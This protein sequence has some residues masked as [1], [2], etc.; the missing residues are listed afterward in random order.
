MLK[1][2]EKD[3]LKSKMIK[4]E[5]KKLV[6]KAVKEGLGIELKE[7]EIEKPKEE[8]FGDYSTNIALVIGEKLKKNP[9]EIANILSSKFPAS[10]QARCGVGKVQSSKF[11]EKIEMAG[12]GFINFFLAKN[13]LIKELTRVLKE[14]EKYGQSE[15]GKGKT[16]VIDYSSPNIAK[17][18]GMG[19]LR[20]TIIG[21]AIYNIYKFLGYKVIGDNHLG[22]WGTQFGKLI[23]AIKRRGGK[24]IKKF[25]IENLEKFY[26]RFH[27]EAE[28]NL[29]LENEARTWFKKLEEGD[30]EAKK[31]WKVCV[32][33]SLKEFKRIYRLLG[34]KFDYILGESFYQKMSSEIIEEAK[35]KK[36]AIESQGAIIIQY[37]NQEFP[38]AMLLKSDKATTYLTRD[39]ATIKYRL[40]KWKPALI[41]YEVGADQELYFKQLFRAAE[42][43]GWTKREKFFHL[44]HG[45]V[46]TKSGK[47]STRKGQTVHL[48]EVLE[49]AILRA[50]EIIEKSETSRGLSEKE[51]EKVAKAVGIGAI[52]YNDLSQHPSGDIIFD[53][54]KILNLKGNSVPYLQYTFARCQSVLK[55][56]NFKPDTSKILLKSNFNKPEREEMMILRRVYRFPEIVQEA[57]EKFSPN[58]IC[59]FI[60]DLAQKFNLFYQLHPIIKAESP[61]L[62]EFRL[63]LTAVVGQILKNSL[64]LLGI[65]APEKM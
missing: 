32:E 55:K 8:R 23:V 54:G 61:E 2:E 41:I 62:K 13:Y 18:F 22:D 5:I 37:P 6:R 21:Q 26:I 12:P 38:P 24:E 29:K 65:S 10:E 52:K 39:L 64:S 57:A 59:N 19:H 50:K 63:T 58:L 51:K 48:E 17:P 4:D 16:I 42:L 40:K 11:F 45:L 60:F 15:V 49:E 46:R 35:K 9:K 36:V 20:S 30:K 7:I 25:T 27:K 14:K 1:R 33:I 44:S 31:L 28:L 34:V 43:L 53:W 3:I 56:A 47:F